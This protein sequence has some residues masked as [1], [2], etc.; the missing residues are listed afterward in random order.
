M[1]VREWIRDNEVHGTVTFD[2]EKAIKQFSQLSEQVVRNELYR[3]GVQGI[4]STVYNGFYVI[5]PPQYAAKGEVP[6]MYYIDQLMNYIRKPYYISLL[7]AAEI[8]GYAHQRPQNFSVT[9]ILP[10]ATTSKSKNAVL[11]WIFR[12]EIPQKFLLTKNSE[13]GIIHYSNAEL[14]AVDIVQYSPHIGGLSR[15]ATVLSELTE[16]TNFEDKV[17]ELLQYTTM[18]TLQRLGYILDEILEESEQAD[19]IYRQLIALNK[20]MVYVPLSN[21]A[22]ESGEKNKKWKI[23]IN[24]EIEVDDV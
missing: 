12:K 23:D 10:K 20:R 1:T 3:L 8:L 4:I 17:E 16:I 14:T 24:T 7:N 2:A 21:Q 5:V 11:N 9:T 19:V 15:A 13:T 6:P 22:E 18:A